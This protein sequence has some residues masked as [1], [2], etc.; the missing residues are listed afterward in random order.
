[1]TKQ[2]DDTMKNQLTSQE[3]IQ[4][5]KLDWTVKQTPVIYDVE[6][7]TYFTDKVV[8]YREDT[9]ESLG[10]VG[11]G[12][13]LVQNS[14]AFAFLDS[15]VGDSIEMFVNAGSFGGGKKV[16]L[17]AKLPGDM[18]FTT[19]KD[20]RG[21]K[22]ITFISSF[23]GSLAVSALFTPV[24]IIC[25]NTLNTALH[26]DD[27]VTHR[28]TNSLSLDQMRIEL[29]VLNRKFDIFTEMSNKMS[30]TPFDNIR[31]LAQKSGLVSKDEIL[32]TKSNNILE[33]LESLFQGTGKGSMME[34]VKGTAWG[35]YNAVTEYIDHHRSSKNDKRQESALLGSGAVAKEKALEYLISL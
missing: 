15:L 30:K 31:D 22:L 20:D 18:Q 26:S 34:G 24:R 11:K 35:A 6:G 1:M 7:K 9:K 13:K 21:D 17:Q 32:T 23:D 4:E 29:G 28:H 27:K 2:K 16:Y 12:Y 8:N 19:N 33:T 5:A 10:I 25:T 3:M 14:T